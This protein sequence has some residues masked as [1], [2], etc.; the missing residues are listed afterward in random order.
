MSRAYLGVFLFAAAG[1]YAL[2]ALPRSSNL[3]PDPASSS[4][5]AAP[6]HQTTAK[7]L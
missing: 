7:K 2:A 6:Q 1:G 4:Q 5:A 3:A